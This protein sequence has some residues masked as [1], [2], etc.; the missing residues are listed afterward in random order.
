M[1]EIVTPVVE[2]IERERLR[3]AQVEE[4][5]LTYALNIPARIQLID[6]FVE[7]IALARRSYREDLSEA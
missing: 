4:R 7:A 1:A 6:Q 3:L 5:A 2:T